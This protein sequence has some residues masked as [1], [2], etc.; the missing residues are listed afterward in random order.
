MH[1]YRT[2]L[3]H[4]DG[5]WLIGFDGGEFGGGLW[6]TNDDGSQTSL[7]L[8]RED[9]HALYHT[10]DGV[11][12]LSGVAHATIDEG[13][14][15]FVFDTSWD[16]AAARLLCD[17]HGSPDASVQD[18]PSTVLVV[19]RSAVLRIGTSGSLETLAHIPVPPPV[20][21]S[22]VMAADRTIYVGVPGYILRL[23]PEPTG[24]SVQWLVPAGNAGSGKP[25]SSQ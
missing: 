8:S 14:V 10:N 19:T 13:K 2:S 9:I 5:S 15:W 17:L 12:V 11:I 18:S 6:S 25:G 4:A 20:V 16:K 22:V 24:Y 23:L 7:V 1:G 21:T 3:H